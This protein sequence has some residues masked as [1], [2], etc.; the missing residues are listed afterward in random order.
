M[1]QVY[2]GVLPVSSTGRQGPVRRACPAPVEGQASRAMMTRK[3]WCDNE[4]SVI[5]RVCSGSLSLGEKFGERGGC[6]EIE[7][8]EP[9][10][11]GHQRNS[12]SD[13]R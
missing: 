13:R 4:I 3:P 1:S 9:S 10:S 7:L 5:A 2:K 8:T 11:M 6:C 12:T